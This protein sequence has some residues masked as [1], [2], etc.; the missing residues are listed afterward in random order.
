MNKIKLLWCRYQE[1]LATLT[2]SFF[3]GYSETERFR[4]ISDYVFGGRNFGK[5][6]SM[7]VIFFPK[8]FKIYS[9]LWECSKKHS[10][11][12]CFWDNCIWIGIIKFSLLITRKF[13]SAANVLTRS[14]K[15][16][17]SIRE[18]FSNSIYLAVINAYDKRAVI[19]FSAVLGHVYHVAC[20]RVLWKGTF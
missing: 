20:W 1:S 19:Q 6:K 13:W 16:C 15:T 7:R 8:I 4:R 5:T 12:F 3:E 14:P 2:R 11:S 18:T 17:M 9:R 10:K